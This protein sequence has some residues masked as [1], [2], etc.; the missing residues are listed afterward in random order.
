MKNIDCEEIVKGLRAN[1]FFEEK[2]SAIIQATTSKNLWEVC[3]LL[4]VYTSPQS[5]DAEK[6]IKKNL[7]INNAEDNISGDGVKNGI[8]YEIKVSVHDVNCKVNIRQ[9]RPHHNV[10]FYI[11]IAFNL[12][13]GSKGEA[14]VF[15]IPAEVIYELVVDY[16]GYTHGTVSK[17]GIV[18]KESISDKNT[19]HEYSL[20]ADPNATYGTKS[21]KLWDRFIEYKVDYTKDSF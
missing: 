13:G 14:Y 19:R 17:N 3:V 16:G 2:E 21:R 8:K 4:R 9:I 15:K 11:I 6:I 12:F 20:T 1:K 7:Q 18:T 10:D 5:T